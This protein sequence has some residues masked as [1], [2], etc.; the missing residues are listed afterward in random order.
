MSKKIMSILMQVL[1]E[2]DAKAVIQ[3]RNT[4]I[5]KPLTDRAASNMVKQF[6]KVQDPSSAVDMMIDKC[7][8]GFNADW[9]H[10][11]VPPGPRMAQGTRILMN[12][13]QRKLN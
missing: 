10:N 9:Y 11:S 8:R 4:T 1:N 5:K 6:Q 12:Q 3:H 7:W 13:E 2:D